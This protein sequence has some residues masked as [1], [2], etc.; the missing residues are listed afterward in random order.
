VA[1][2][3]AIVNDM[4]DSTIDFVDILTHYKSGK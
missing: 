3:D 1:K 4:E 2:V